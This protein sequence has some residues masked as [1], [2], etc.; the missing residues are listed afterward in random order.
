[1]MTQ[2]LLQLPEHPASAWRV[3]RRAPDAPSNA[4]ATTE[5]AANPPERPR[6]RVAPAMKDKT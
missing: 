2:T 6:S 1:M 4:V 3:S 5:A